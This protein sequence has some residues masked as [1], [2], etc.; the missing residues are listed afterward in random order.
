MGVQYSNGIWRTIQIPDI[1]DHKQFFSVQFSDHHLNHFLGAVQTLHNTIRG[2]GEG[3]NLCA[4]LWSN[5]RVQ[6]VFFV[7]RRGKGSILGHN[8]VT[9]L[10]NDPLQ[11]IIFKKLW[12]NLQ[13]GFN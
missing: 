2:G 13:K 6:I 11:V 12:G 10:M 3:V 8:G 1:L 7:L 4:T 9:L 5:G